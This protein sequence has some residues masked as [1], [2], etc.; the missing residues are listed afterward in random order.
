MAQ[1]LSLPRGRLLALVA[2]VLVLHALLADH[3]V[4]TVADWSH[5]ASS[6]ERMTV[7]YVRQMQLA[8]P[9]QVARPTD[10]TV[11]SAL[12][13]PAPRE[14]AA[15][16]PDQDNEPRAP[17]PVASAPLAEA[18]A[19]AEAEAEEEAG[20][21][22]EPVA[23]A[24]STAAAEARM[25]AAWPEPN[26]AASAPTPS[27]AV[28]PVLDARPNPDPA[29][30][31]AA[32]QTAALYPQPTPGPLPDRPPTITAAAS[33]PPPFAWPASTRLSYRLSGQYRGEVHGQA[34]VAWVLAAPRY[35]V[36]L[37]VSV[38]LP[39]APLFSRRM[40][41]DGRLTAAGLRPERYDERSKM[42][43]RDARALRLTLD[44]EGVLLADGR[45]WTR[46]P[47]AASLAA[48]DT[49]PAPAGATGTAPGAAPGAAPGDTAAT[50]IQDSASQFV[51]LSYLFTVN[52]ALLTPG[53][54]VGF[55]LALPRRVEPWVYEVVGTQTQHTPFGALETYHV[56]PRPGTP[57]GQDLLA[58]AWF[59]PQL[60]Y[61][62]VR[63]RIEQDA[64]VYIDLVLDRRPE[65]AAAAR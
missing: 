38:G 42:A 59:A 45:R 56:R 8:A 24:A 52:P 25:A 64:E 3:L 48:I 29:A 2:A 46:P 13:A 47:R 58:E 23:T 49:A 26:A 40:T 33:Q 63:I 28:S 43:F 32:A 41:S 36:H 34:Q 60:A 54:T 53:Q 37:D 19:A 62:P 1:R 7:A 30:G 4:D 27:A 16:R 39:M 51:Q 21:L 12:R 22:P 14:P 17:E 65:L 44:D 31:L 50:A 55:P 10:I 9:T 57:R 11:P 18:E 6:V 20:V 5:E 35:Q 15:P 61:L